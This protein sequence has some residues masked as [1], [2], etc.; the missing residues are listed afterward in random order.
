MLRV[1]HIVPKHVP[2]VRH[3]EHLGGPGFLD[4]LVHPLEDHATGIAFPLYCGEHSQYLVAGRCLVY[5][6]M[7]KAVGG[8]VGDARSV[9]HAKL[10][11]EGWI[12]LVAFHEFLKIA[13]VA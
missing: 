8:E 3:H 5:T 11:H 4:P 1:H 2:V 12:A 7:V 6:A 10:G 13:T 9:G